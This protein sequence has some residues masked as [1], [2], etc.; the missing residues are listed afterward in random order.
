MTVEFKP[1]L[2]CRWFGHKFKPTKYLIEIIPG[3]LASDLEKCQKCGCGRVF[4]FG[5]F[6]FFLPTAV[7]EFIQQR[8]AVEHG[9]GKVVSLMDFSS[10]RSRR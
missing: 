7:T 6:K 8:E 3:I 10:R 2:K 4:H 5:G 1:P 9:D